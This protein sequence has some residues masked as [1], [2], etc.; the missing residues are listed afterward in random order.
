MIGYINILHYSLFH[1][2]KVYYY[3]TK[4]FDGYSV[5]FITGTK[6]Y[7]NYS[8]IYSTLKVIHLAEIIQ[9][10]CL[11]GWLAV[12]R[13]VYSPLHRRRYCV[14]AVAPSCGRGLDKLW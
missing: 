5:I 12:V 2:S 6:M 11:K 13:L 10:R 3:N 7:M 1:Q 4:H 8:A 14:V 9:K